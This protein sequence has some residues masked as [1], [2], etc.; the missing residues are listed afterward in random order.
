MSQKVEIKKVGDWNLMDRLTNVMKHDI[1]DTLE[2]EMKQIGLE[3]EAKAVSH[4]KNQDL[5]WK[6]YKDNK[7]SESKSRRGLS[8]KMLVATSDYFNAITSWAKGLSAYSGVRRRVKNR[9]GDYIDVIAAVQ[10]YGSKKGGV[11]ARPLWRPVYKEM[12]SWIKQRNIEKRVL[13]SLK[14]R[15]GK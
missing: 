2:T 3:G 4:I 6:P 15:T 14:N 12:L 8:D 7:Y 11:E 5:S 1:G 10:E 9:D 13:D